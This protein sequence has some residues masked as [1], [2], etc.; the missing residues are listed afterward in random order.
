[1]IYS[2]SILSC[3]DNSGALLL[4]CINI[5]NTKAR[6]SSKPAN[7]IL[8][9]I[10]TLRLLRKIKIGELKKALFVRGRKWMTRLNGTSLKFNQNAAILVND[11][12]KPLNNRVF[13]PIYREIIFNKN[14]FKFNFLLYSTI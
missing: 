10:K 11:K 4:R 2:E 3:A 1:M 14:L 8:V 5:Y 13:G 12:L 9:S 7:L 6:N